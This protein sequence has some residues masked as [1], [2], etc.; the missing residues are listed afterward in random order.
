MITIRRLS[1]SDFLCLYRLFLE[2]YFAN[3]YKNSTENMTEKIIAT[4]TVFS[5]VTRRRSN[6]S[7]Q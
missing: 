5:T 3:K 4:A 1:A 2:I 6:L 7:K